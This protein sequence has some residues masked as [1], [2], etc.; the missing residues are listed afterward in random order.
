MYVCLLVS[1][2][3]LQQRDLLMA[4]GETR[5]AANMAARGAH[6]AEIQREIHLGPRERRFMTV[7]EKVARP[8]VSWIWNG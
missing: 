1:H 2:Q 8:L 4:K 3:S 7:S 6:R 5:L